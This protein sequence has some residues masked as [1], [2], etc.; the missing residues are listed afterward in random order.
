MHATVGTKIFL[1]VMVT[2]LNSEK[3]KY[4]SQGQVK[5]PKRLNGGLAASFERQTT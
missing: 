2:V 1:T 4:S 3:L 5:E